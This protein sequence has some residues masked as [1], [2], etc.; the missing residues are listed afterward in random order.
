VEDFTQDIS[1]FARD[2]RGFV[3]GHDLPAEWFAVPDHI[4]VKGA[5]AAD[6]ERIVQLF[7]RCRRR[8]VI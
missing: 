5:D 8:S 1:K 6:Y 7:C 3:S 4:A 2:L